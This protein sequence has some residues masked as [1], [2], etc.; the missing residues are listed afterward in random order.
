MEL[1]TGVMGSFE[2][3]FDCGKLVGLVEVN[4]SRSCSSS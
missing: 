2:D 3:P 4:M 1:S